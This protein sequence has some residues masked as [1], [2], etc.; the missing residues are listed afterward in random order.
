MPADNV[1]PFRRPPKRPA[2]PQQ[3]GW[4]LKTHR[5]KAVLA[6]LLTLAAFAL[7]LVFPAAPLSLIALGVAVAALLF[8]YSN[9]GAGM[10]WANTHHE[11]ALRTLVIGYVII[12]L[13]SLLIMVVNTPLTPA[14]MR[15]IFRKFS[16]W[17]SVAVA[18]WA[19]ARA[20]IALVLAALRQ[21]LRNPRGWL[22]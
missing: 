11:H 19:G 2:A 5:G 6:H 4:G 8:V 17:T 7:A 21:P 13:V 10:P 12:T 3:S 18:L 22:V 9:R 14:S 16:F 15:D 20:L 1:T